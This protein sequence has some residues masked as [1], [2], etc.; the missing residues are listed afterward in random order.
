LLPD[1]LQRVKFGSPDDGVP[2]ELN[3]EKPELPAA[4]AVIDSGVWCA[5]PDLNVVSNWTVD[6][7]GWSGCEDAYGK[8]RF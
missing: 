7:P 8:K 6:R 3:W 2:A 4:V 1:T 5:H